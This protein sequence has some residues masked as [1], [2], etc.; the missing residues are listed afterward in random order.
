MLDILKGVFALALLVLLLIALNTKIVQKNKAIVVERLGKFLKIID[1]PGFYFTIPVV[2][3]VLQTV[4]LDIQNKE[5]LI[6]N[7]FE[8]KKVPLSLKYQIFDVKLFV[9]AEL[10]SYSKLSEYITQ[11]IQS[12]QQLTDENTH[13]IT[14]YAESLGITI[15]EL[16]VK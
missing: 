16:C 5:I 10:D 13:L 6:D 4:P 9:Y 14:E 2:D 11:H 7:E 12:E 1:Q 3:R 8:T 15:I